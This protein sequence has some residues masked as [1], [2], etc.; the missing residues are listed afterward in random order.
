[1]SSTKQ[2]VGITDVAIVDAAVLT[3]QSGVTVKEA[4]YPEGD[5]MAGFVRTKLLRAAG[6]E[7]EGLMISHAVREEKEE[8]S[9]PQ[10]AEPVVVRPF[11]GTRGE[12]MEF[13]N[14]NGISSSYGPGSEEIKEITKAHDDGRPVAVYEL[15]Q[16]M[17]D[18]GRGNLPV[19]RIWIEYQNGE[20]IAYQG[21]ESVSRSSDNPIVAIE[22]VNGGRGLPPEYTVISKSDK[23]NGTHKGDFK[24]SKY[25]KG[26]TLAL[27]YLRQRGI[28]VRVSSHCDGQVWAGKVRL[29]PTATGRECVLN[30]KGKWGGAAAQSELAVTSV[31]I[32][33]PSNGVI[34]DD[35][36]QGVARASEVFLYANPRFPG[37]VLVD[38]DNSAVSEARKLVK[39]GERG[40]IMCLDGVLEKEEDGSVRHI[41]VDGLKV[42]LEKDMRAILPWSVQG[43]DESSDCALRVSRSHNSTSYDASYISAPVLLAVQML[44]DKE[45]MRR[46]ILCAMNNPEIRFLEFP[47]DQWYSYLLRRKMS[48]RMAELVKEIWKEEYGDDTV[49]ASSEEQ[50]GLYR[51]HVGK[52]KKAVIV[53]CGLFLFLERVGVMT[54]GKELQKLNVKK[55]ES[56]N[57]L[58]VPF[59]DSPDRFDILMDHVARV[60]GSVKL[61]E[62]EGGK[63]MVFTIPKVVRDET[64]FN[65]QT[66]SNEGVIARTAAV[67]AEVAKVNCSIFVLDGGYVY[68]IRI[69]VTRGSG[70]FFK[71]N[72]E[73]QEFPR[74]GKPQYNEY[75]DGTYIVFSGGE[76][77]SF[78]SGGANEYLNKRR[79]EMEAR[80]RGM[81]SRKEVRAPIKKSVPEVSIGQIRIDKKD[82]SEVKIHP[83]SRC[84]K[85]YYR[86][87]V[88]TD[89]V[90]DSVEN[91]GYWGN[92][93]NWV[94]VDDVL[95]GEPEKYES[96]SVIQNLDSH[97]FHL[98]VPSGHKIFAIEASDD[99]GVELYRDTRSGIYMVRGSA[100]EFVYYTWSDEVV[101]YEKVSPTD[102]E[103]KD[104]LSG[105]NSDCLSDEWRKFIKSIVDGPKLIPSVKIELLSE[106][107]DKTFRYSRAY[108]KNAQIRGANLEEIAAKILNTSSGICNICAT[109]FALLLRS[110]GIPS[111]VVGGYWKQDEHHGGSH[112]WV[113]YFD[114][115]TWKTV[116]PGLG[117]L[118]DF[119]DIDGKTRN[120]VWAELTGRLARSE[121]ARD[122]LID[123]KRT[124]DGI[125][126]DGRRGA[127]SLVEAA[128]F[129]TFRAGFQDRV[130]KELK[131]LLTEDQITKGQKGS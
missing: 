15:M 71:T 117:V 113:E 19:P 55:I 128:P 16:G 35:V 14:G 116:D 83:K 129:V 111:R 99:A 17:V 57:D 100:D 121:G 33:R 86:R 41:Y 3:I 22:F 124:L 125:V 27:T 120:E 18:F 8:D 9:A 50:T 63:R 31:R 123:E 74:E 10:T 85:G 75:Q 69:A 38:K 11:V 20:R 80:R 43:L 76:I 51:Q 34:P 58:N 7:P 4:H 68:E 102:E 60:D 44:E 91:E 103:T 67:I 114:E 94:H 82:D 79:K 107:W 131:T 37:A 47:G 84:P 97:E 98:D 24:L 42:P 29:V 78:T 54:A 72:L 81:P 23:E 108:S 26:L 40:E 70:N 122:A 89:F 119:C 59:V 92:E 66:V 49:I 101:D 48:P 118:E 130:R 115:G 110:V 36:I 90:Y 30:L 127:R 96:A 106:K 95:S 56:L 1:M 77:E 52:G 87:N 93:Y 53:P 73:I 13:E 112:A 105:G 5:V 12:G 126:A 32:E 6:I 61:S 2:E 64:E 88:G 109:G 65:G 28:N 46:V 62:G 104:F 21:I 39:I 45:L 25:G